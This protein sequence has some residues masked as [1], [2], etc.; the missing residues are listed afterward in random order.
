MCTD[1]F[2]CDYVCICGVY[3][4][5][6]LFGNGNHSYWSMAPNENMWTIIRTQRFG[7]IF[8]DNSNIISLG[9]GCVDVA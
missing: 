4:V 3:D 5:R 2:V 8:V 1:N 9:V 7:N 6:N